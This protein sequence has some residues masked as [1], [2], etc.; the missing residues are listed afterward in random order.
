VATVKALTAEQK[1][2]HRAL[3]DA[4]GGSVAV[5]KLIKRRLEVDITYNAVTNWKKRGIPDGYRPCLIVA[6]EEIGTAVPKLFLDPG[7]LPPP[8][9]K[10]V[11]FL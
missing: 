1:T 9:A 5:A 2:E 3:I 11:P 7:K 10:E 6:A 8:K 4:L